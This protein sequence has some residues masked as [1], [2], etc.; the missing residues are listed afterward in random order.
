[1]SQRGKEE[2]T[3]FHEERHNFEYLP[4]VPAT[5]PGIDGKRLSET[6]GPDMKSTLNQLKEP[7]FI[8]VATVHNDD[9][10]KT[11]PQQ[12]AWHNLQGHVYS[13]SVQLATNISSRAGTSG[14]YCYETDPKIPHL[15]EYQ[16]PHMGSSSQFVQ[17][18]LGIN[19]PT[20]G[21]VLLGSDIHLYPPRRATNE[22]TID[23]GVHDMPSVLHSVSTKLPVETCLPSSHQGG[24][25]YNPATNMPE[26]SCAIAKTSSDQHIIPPQGHSIS[27][28]VSQLRTQ[29]IPSRYFT[30]PRSVK[31]VGHTNSYLYNPNQGVHASN[32]T[33]SSDVGCLPFND[34]QLQPQNEESHPQISRAKEHLVPSAQQLHQA[35][36]T[37]SGTTTTST[38]RGTLV[39]P[40]QELDLPCVTVPSVNPTN[41]NTLIG[42]PE[43][44]NVR[45]S[46]QLRGFAP[47]SRAVIGG[48]TSNQQLRDRF[49]NLINKQKGFAAD[50]GSQDAGSEMQKTN[51]RV[52]DTGKGNYSYCIN[53]D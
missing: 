39:P 32:T 8:P 33:K 19:H 1:M 22:G 43:P 16:Q 26:R 37:C 44:L 38:Y 15:D 7:T 31:P 20:A 28:N 13:D 2:S 46:G 35:P 12:H 49:Q 48:P 52:V 9:A 24:C 50:R 23:V 25:Q 40:P 18:E 30:D 4:K 42:L 45:L 6:K 11:S 3:S 27:H 17:H 36:N 41:R 53:V 34:T 51:D 14:Q 47:V 5:Q 29:T 10:Q 21:H